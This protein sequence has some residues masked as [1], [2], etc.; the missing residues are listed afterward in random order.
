MS[1]PS[2]E[3]VEVA[4]LPRLGSDGQFQIFRDLMGVPGLHLVVNVFSEPLH[5]A[6]YQ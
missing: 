2:G 4:L 6:L 5:A 1:G 3:D